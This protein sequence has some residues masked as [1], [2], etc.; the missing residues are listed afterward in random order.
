MKLRF[1]ADGVG[2]C[3]LFGLVC[4]AYAPCFS[5]DFLN[6]DD[7]WLIVNNP[8]LA[9]AAHGT[10]SAIWSDFRFATR[11]A[12]GAEYLPL[13]D[14]LVWFERWLFGTS[15]PS[16]HALSVLIYAA[17]CLIF[18]RYLIVVCGRGLVAEASALVFALH[19]VHVE[20]VAWLAGQK[21][22]L[23]LLFIALA[24]WTHAK[25]IAYARAWV[26]LFIA[27]ACFS[28]SM[29]VSVIVLLLATDLAL[30]R[31]FDLVTYASSALVIAASLAVH[32]YVGSI[33]HMIAAPLGG[34]RWNALLSMGP[35]WLRYVGLCLLP[36]QLS[37]EHVVEPL[38]RV[39]LPSLVGYSFVLGTASYACFAWWHKRPLPLVIWLWFFA[40]LLPVSQIVAP[41][42]NRMA[43][44]Y[45]WLSVMALALL[46]GSGVAKLGTVP[47]LHPAWSYGVV[48]LLC[49]ILI[50]ATFER[51]LMFA[52]SVLLFSDGAQKTQTGTLSPYQLGSA[53]EAA[54][55]PLD[56][57]VSYR[58]VLR[59]A[60]SGRIENARRATNNLAKLLSARGQLGQAEAVLR[61]GLTRFSDDA[62]M[63]NNLAKV[64]AGTGREQEAAVWRS[65]PTSSNAKAGTTEAP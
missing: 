14:M 2:A 18:R 16:M 64:L 8:V 58:E 30:R 31:R 48:A 26:P 52:D 36:W 25:G 46:V 13:R 60:P 50:G 39:T 55:R 22:V 34:S 20:S 38:S 1:Q 53:F 45:L 10:L 54:G 35:V 51:S 47:R 33:V 40:P 44:R 23:A 41:L 65:P 37:I 11:F 49:T 57:E 27:C 21:D 59:R 32:L 6:Y 15:A 7:P 29:S 9:P 62:K 3:L 61:Q 63:R 43:D 42:Q 17:S 4:L 19:P 24:L 12:L 5:A 56:A 28:K